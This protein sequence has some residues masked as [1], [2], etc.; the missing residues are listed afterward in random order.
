MTTEVR[1]S[2]RL[3]RTL[4][5]DG[6]PLR[7]ATDRAEAWIRI[8]LIAVFLVAGPLAAVAVG[9][10]AAHVGT[11]AARPAPI[12][13]VMA[14]VP[15]NDAGGPAWTQAQWQSADTSP[16]ASEALAVVMTLGFTALALLAAQRLTRALL[17]R[18]RLTAWGTAWATVG[19]RWSRRTS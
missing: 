13:H 3:A 10:W 5:L 19:P 2:R 1:G 17:I 7:R 18:R 12:H 4:G 15:R 9:G 14:V 16:G 6:N 8:G 11:T